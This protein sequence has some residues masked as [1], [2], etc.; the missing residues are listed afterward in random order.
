EVSMNLET[1]GRWRSPV[2]LPQ[3]EAEE[4]RIS[5]PWMATGPPPSGLLDADEESLVLRRPGVGV[6]GG[7]REQ[8]GQRP[9]VAGVARVA[10]VDGEADLPDRLAVDLERVEPLG[11][12]RHSLDLS[13]LGDHLHLRAVLDAL[14]PG[15]PLGDR[16]EEARLQ[17]VE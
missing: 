6:H 15:Q 16:D 9:R 3:T 12:H 4:R 5:S 2:L 11:D 1:T 13:P 17:L 8:V 10:P 7:W 14:L